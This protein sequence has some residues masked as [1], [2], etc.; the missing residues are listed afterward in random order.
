MSSCFE[1]EYHILKNF[2][3]KIFKMVWE[4]YNKIRTWFF[5]FKFRKFG[6]TCSS[7]SKSSNLWVL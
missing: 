3:I 4:P 6:S 5:T 1:V 7:F 2:L